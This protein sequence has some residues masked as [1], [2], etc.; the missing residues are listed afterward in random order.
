[1]LLKS[2]TVPSVAFTPLNIL[3]I[4]LFADQHR[5][6]MKSLCRSAGSLTWHAVFSGE[7]RSRKEV[8]YHII[9]VIALVINSANLRRF[10]STTTERC[11]EKKQHNKTNNHKCSICMNF[12]LS[13]VEAMSAFLCSQSQT[14]HLWGSWAH[15]QHPS[16][17][18]ALT[19]LF[20]CPTQWM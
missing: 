6:M 4:C 11:R 18:P 8:I 12:H 20:S 19:P 2:P 3:P 16:V 9:P 5:K 14:H 17:S 1:M 13:L 15:P 7:G 10:T